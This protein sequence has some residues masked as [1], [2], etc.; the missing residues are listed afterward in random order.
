[1]P[2]DELDKVK[3]ER[4]LDLIFFGDRQLRWR[5]SG[6]EGQRACYQA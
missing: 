2:L 3:Q 1:V 5:V 4:G 6:R